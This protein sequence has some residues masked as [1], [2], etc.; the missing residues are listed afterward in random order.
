MKS[1]NRSKIK[2]SNLDSNKYIYGERE[3]S[4]G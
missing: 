3:I 2:T 1:E 4:K